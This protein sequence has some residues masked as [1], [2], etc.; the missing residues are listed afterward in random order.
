MDKSEQFRHRAALM[1]LL[2]A[3]IS[4]AESRAALLQ[5]ALLWDEA[6]QAAEAGSR[7]LM[8]R[9]FETPAARAPQ[10]EG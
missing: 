6:A 5:S 3:S 2:A 4:F 8:V 10:G 7:S 9:P 1:R